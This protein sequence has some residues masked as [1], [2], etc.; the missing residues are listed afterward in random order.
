MKTRTIDTNVLVRLLVDDHTEQAVLAVKL[1][2]CFQLVVLPTVILETEWVLRSRFHVERPKIIELLRYVTAL[3]RF[4]VIDKPRV[5]RAIDCF[6][7]GMDFADAMHLCFV[8]EG[9]TFVTFD[10]DLARLAKR[11]IDTVSV[12]L[13]S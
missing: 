4:L 5:I 2:E 6:E 9:E 1:A 7:K 11:H 12:E 13:A 3:E 8:D 10:R